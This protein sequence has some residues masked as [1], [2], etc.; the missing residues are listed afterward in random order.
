MTPK[1][2]VMI[3]L[4]EKEFPKMKSMSPLDGAKTRGLLRKASYEALEEI[5]RR[6]IPFVSIEAEGEMVRRARKEGGRV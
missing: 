2:A 1:E 5:V 4:F 3:D 6:K